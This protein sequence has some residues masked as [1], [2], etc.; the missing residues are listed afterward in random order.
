MRLENWVVTFRQEDPYRA[1]EAKQC[2]HGNVYGHPDHL[3]GEEVTTSR[4]VAT[5]DKF[6]TTSSGSKYEL[7]AVYPDYEKQFPN[8]RER[9]LNQGVINVWNRP[10]VANRGM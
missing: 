2:L 7:G 9:L 10:T 5:D 8:A 4:I 3:D 1:P 6:V